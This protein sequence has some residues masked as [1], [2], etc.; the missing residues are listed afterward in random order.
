MNLGAG[1]DATVH[2]HCPTLPGTSPG[3]GPVCDTG[4]GIGYDVG[5]KSCTFSVS[6]LKHHGWTEKLCHYLEEALLEMRELT[7]IEKATPRSKL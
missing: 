4:V 1:L 5:A 7:E 3:F 2:A 6:A